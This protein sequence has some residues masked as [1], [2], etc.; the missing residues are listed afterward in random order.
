MKKRRKTRSRVEEEFFKA[1]PTLNNFELNSVTSLPYYTPKMNLKRK[2]EAEL[3]L[4][5][6][7]QYPE[8][9]V[10]ETLLDYYNGTSISKIAKKL[11]CSKSQASKTLFKYKRRVL[12]LISSGFKLPV[13]N[14]K[15]HGELILQHKGQVKR[16]YKIAFNGSLVWV[17]EEGLILPEDVQDYLDGGPEIK[18]GILDSPTWGV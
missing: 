14:R 7:S 8:E 15:K 5:N 9:E 16:L 12:K 10:R 13:E 2:E 6:I 1:H 18:G 11:N 4:A 17:S 3:I